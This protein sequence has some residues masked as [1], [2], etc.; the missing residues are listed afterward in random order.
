MAT[1]RTGFVCLGVL[2]LLCVHAHSQTDSGRRLTQADTA[3][4]DTGHPVAPARAALS[5]P[6]MDSPANAPAV[7]S[8]AAGENVSMQS[9]YSIYWLTACGLLGVLAGAIG[10]R[11]L[12]KPDKGQDDASQQPAAGAELVQEA[13][14]Q[15]QEHT[16]LADM[17]TA[18]MLENE[19]LKQD[20][21]ELE[22]RLTAMDHAAGI[23]DLD[24][25]QDIV[26]YMP[27]PNMN[28]R[29]Q[30]A[31]RRTD[32]ADS[33]YEFHVARANQSVASFVFIARDA[34]LNAAIGN[35]PSWISVACDRTNQPTGT[36]TRVRTDSPGLAILTNGEW[37]IT[38]KARITYL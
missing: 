10:Y 9:G 8:V 37:E 20:K 7:K 22:K 38:R 3:I 32:A 31:S 34:Y 5:A 27:Q 4:S 19:Q 1:N 25:D 36:T 17:N 16:G 11:L 30:E 29:F 28:G 2:M 15:A 23:T 18:L 6:A 21:A 13:R 33:L 12:V 26:F 14:Q 24:P 35:E